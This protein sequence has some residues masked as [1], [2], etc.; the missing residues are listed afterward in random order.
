MVGS[1]GAAVS[2]KALVFLEGSTTTLSDG[3]EIRARF[4][5][6]CAIVHGRGVGMSANEMMELVLA[7]GLPPKEERERILREKLADDG[8]TTSPSSPPLSD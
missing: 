2:D 7:D 1:P 6:A 8:G 5:K 4:Q 3:R